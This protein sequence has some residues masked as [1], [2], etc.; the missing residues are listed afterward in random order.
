[1]FGYSQSELDV[2]LG[3][4]KSSNTI[5]MTLD[6]KTFSELNE[7]D[8]FTVFGVRYIKTHRFSSLQE[9]Q[10]L[11]K[12]LPI[13]FRLFETQYD[14]DLA[15]SLRSKFFNGFDTCCYIRWI[16]REIGFGA[17]ATKDISEDT[18]VGEYVGEIK[19]SLRNSIKHN[20]FCFHYPTKFFS[21]K[22]YIIDAFHYGNEFRFLNHSDT[23]NLTRKWV[24]DRNI[25]HLV[26]V[27][28]EDIPAHREL[29]FDYGKHFHE[30]Y[31][32]RER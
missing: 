29:T 11:S 12:Q 22:Y 4:K 1:M 18:I 25:L 16:S 20:P 10:F 30:K 6:G 19:C 8:F 31:L 21:W 24:I 13:V 14:K 5:L 15:S 23:P 9:I 32:H 17:F 2:Y 26:F 27:A 7:D 3:S 28:N